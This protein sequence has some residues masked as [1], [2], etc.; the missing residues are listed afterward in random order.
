M[1]VKLFTHTDLDG[2]G[3]YIVASEV[4]GELNVDVEF[5]DYHNVNEKLNE[6]LDNVYAYERV[7]HDLILI[8]DISPD[9]NTA[10]KINSMIK[11][12]N[13]KIK[14]LDH[15]DTALWLNKYDWSQVQPIELDDSGKTSGTSLLFDY[16]YGEKELSNELAVFAEWVRRYDCWEWKTRYNNQQEPYQLNELLKIYGREK[17]IAEMKHRIDKKKELILYEDKMILEQRERELERYVESKNKQIKKIDV[18][19]HTIGVV[20][21]ESDLSIL[22]NRLCEMNLDIDFVAMINLSHNTIS[23]RAVKD[24]VHVGEFAKTYGGGGHPKA[25]GSQFDDVLVNEFISKL[26]KAR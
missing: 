11:S 1:K 6:Y 22:G 21:A 20:F 18:G 12:D 25:S 5:C 4:L 7:P 23:Y 24:D 10:E 14:L 15:H 8:T 2:L 9:E 13:I 16:F 19:V 26:L 3:C 17:F